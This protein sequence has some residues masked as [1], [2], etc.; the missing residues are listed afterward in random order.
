M[1][2]TLALSSLDRPSAN[3]AKS[4]YSRGMVRFRALGLFS[5]HTSVCKGAP[6]D[7]SLVSF[8]LLIM[9]SGVV[10]FQTCPGTLICIRGVS[11]S[12]QLGSDSTRIQE[13]LVWG[14]NSEYWSSVDFKSVGF[15]AKLDGTW[16]PP[17]P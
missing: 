15:P 2:T 8:A 5:F 12:S 11:I 9:L 4:I 14:R 13:E 7:R 17:V 6:L 1:L 10:A 16:P 3:N